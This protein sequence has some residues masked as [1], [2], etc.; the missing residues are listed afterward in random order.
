MQAFFIILGALIVLVLGL[1]IFSLFLSPTV[2]VERSLVIPAA[3]D[4]IF[5][6][7][8]VVR[9][10]ELWSPWKEQDPAVKITYG[11]KESGPG[12]GY[13]W[14]SNNRNVGKGHMA[15]TESKQDQYIA[16]N[17]DF[18][19]MGVAKGYFRFESVTGGTLVTWGMT[20]NMGHQPLKK[21]MGLMMDKWVGNDFEKGLKSLERT[22]TQ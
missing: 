16:T 12:A 13:S 8:N 10:W 22:V 9:N 1:F 2:K 20:C 15:I 21:V 6:L 14:E 19:G 3:A 7:V 11:E 4:A 17:T 18:M 5:P